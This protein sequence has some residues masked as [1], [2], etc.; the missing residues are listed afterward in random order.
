MD[1]R[2]EG[3]FL[4]TLGM[5][6]SDESKRLKGR[7]GVDRPGRASGDRYTSWTSSEGH[8]EP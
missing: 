8:G 4:E 6:E 5:S 3:E 1:F 7:V 2:N